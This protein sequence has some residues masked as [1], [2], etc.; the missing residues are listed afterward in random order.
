MF[1]HWEISRKLKIAS[2]LLVALPI[3]VGWG[4]IYLMKRVQLTGDLHQGFDGLEVHV[5]ELRQAEKSYFLAMKSWD[6]DLSSRLNRD[7]ENHSRALD[8]IAK[9]IADLQHHELSEAFGLPTG[10]KDVMQSLNGYRNA[11]S[12]LVATREAIGNHKSGLWQEAYQA[13]EQLQASLAAGSQDRWLELQLVLQTYQSNPTA[14]VLRRARQRLAALLDTTEKLPLSSSQKLAMVDAAHKL[15]AILAE[16]AVKENKIQLTGDTGL[17]QQMNRHY[18]DMLDKLHAIEDML[19]Q[20]VEDTI[21]FAIWGVI[22]TVALALALGFLISLYLSNL[23]SVRLG[24]FKERTDAIASGNYDIAVSDL[25]SNDEIGQ[26]ARSFGVMTKHLQLRL[27][28]VEGNNWLESS[29]ASIMSGVSRLESLN[30]LGEYV[31]SELVPKVSGRM[32]VFYCRDGATQSEY[33]LLASYAYTRRSIQLESVTLREGIVGQAIAEAKQ[34]LVTD[35][36]DGYVPVSSGLGQ[37]KPAAVLV[38]PILL[39]AR[40][41]G[42]IELA[43]FQNLSDLQLKLVAKVAEGLAAVIANLQSKHATE[44]L[45]RE[46]QVQNEEIQN[47]A[48]ELEELNSQLEA[49]SHDLRDSQDEMERRN[50]ELRRAERELTKRAE[51]LAQSSKYKSEFLAN[52][53]HELRTPLNSIL[54]LSKL[55]GKEQGTNLT[56][57]QQKHVATI[58]AAGSDLL[59]LINEVLDMSKI[60]AGHM[61]V[62]VTKFPVKRI[63]KD[64]RDLFAAQAEQNEI[65]LNFEITDDVPEVMINDYDRIQQVIKNFLSN[66]IKYTAKGTVGLKVFVPANEPQ[67]I[68]F[69]VSDTG[70]GIPKDKQALV[71]QAFQQIDGSTT[72]KYRGTGLG[73]SISAKIAVLLGGQITLASTEGEGS[74]FT[75][76][77]PCNLEADAAPPLAKLAEV[78]PGDNI[79]ELKGHVE[80]V[81]DD[82]ATINMDDKILLIIE[83]DPQFAT[84]IME[85]ARKWDY[86]VL[87]ADTG[88]AGIRLAEKYIPTAI[89]LDI[90]LPVFDGWMVL[91]AIKSNPETR[92]I[93][94]LIISGSDDKHFGMTLGAFDYYQKPLRDED[95]ENAFRDLGKF[96][97]K[98]VKNVLVIEDNPTEREAIIEL[99]GNDDLDITSVGTGE[100]ALIRVQEIDY[101]CIILDLKLPDISG[102]D[103][104]KSLSQDAKL[105]RIPI[106]IYTG[107]DL[108]EVEE[109]SLRKMSDSIIVK[110]VNSPGRLLEETS[111]FLHR[112]KDKIG[113]DRLK[114]MTELSEPEKV[115]M[116]KRIL[117]VDDDIRNV[118]ALAAALETKGLMVLTAANGQDALDLLADEE[119]I[120]LILMDMM[121]PLMDGYEACRKVREMPEYRDVPIIALTAKAMKGDRRQC[122][123]AGASDYLSKPIDIQQLVSLIRVWLSARIRKRAS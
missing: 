79:A 105:K 109:L 11:F 1:K 61:R 121:M 55:M 75:F 13:S 40:V 92:H 45:L 60:E 98:Q 73:L 102:N 100:E 87:V 31:L 53:S 15:Q 96:S 23:I 58:H 37:A 27:Q 110:S 111:I 78:I 115:F 113:E 81:D 28:D 123:D 63:I 39:D 25:E 34:I 3:M 12:E 88:S 29:L 21:A 76:T 90:K 117:V 97:A 36:P 46:T 17:L 38:Q 5:A 108:S 77:L 95:L 7:L 91:Q 19:A 42:V 72:R 51:E 93:P 26:L 59:Q 83:D 43:S 10:T 9:D 8:G 4:A 66:A 118:Y 65:K 82:V 94:V 22:I 74:T 50:H 20:Q 114:L 69:A 57:Q 106:I 89:V 112:I 48:E 70:I 18:R 49:Q 103:I 44:E 85:N 62:E 56:P 86:K 6:H 64:A 24:V 71:F 14:E 68:A 116:D 30:E 120:D 33:K 52:M 80:K 104:L 32:A 35:I 47:Q 99:I 119:P 122:I 16:I 41:L 101:D 84:I 54:I 2:L 107:K 67:N